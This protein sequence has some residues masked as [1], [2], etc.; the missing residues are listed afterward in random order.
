M[1]FLPEAFL[2]FSKVLHFTFYHERNR[3]NITVRHKIN[4]SWERCCSPWLVCTCFIKCSQKTEQKA[5]IEV[6]VTIHVTISLGCPPPRQ[7]C[8]ILPFV[9]NW[10]AVQNYI[11]LLPRSFHPQ[12]MSQ[13]LISLLGIFPINFF[14]DRIQYNNIFVGYLNFYVVYSCHFP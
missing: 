13:L 4:S 6:V 7:C 5:S 9:F 1:D 14:P 8:H 12:K 10:A 3:N 2:L 11:F